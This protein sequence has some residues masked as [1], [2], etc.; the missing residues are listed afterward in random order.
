[1]RLPRDDVNQRMRNIIEYYERNYREDVRLQNDAGVL[2]LAR[3][4]D[5]LRRFLPDPPAMVLDIGGGPGVYASWLASL[6]FEV[7]LLDPVP[8]HLVHAR[9]SLGVG[10]VVFGDARELPFASQSADA[11]LLLGPLYHLI[12]RQDRIAALAEARRVL[13]A[14]GVMV[15]AGISRFASLLDGVTT[16]AIDDPVFQRIVAQDLRDG[17]H[18]SESDRPEYFTTAYFHHP[19]E[20]RGEALEAG[21]IDPEIIAVEGPVW[22]APDFQER[23]RDPERR[24]V[25][26]ELAK[27]V[28]REPSLLGLSL[29]F[30]VICGGAK[31]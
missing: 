25:L 21:F 14:D 3:T 9:D 18:R 7:C 1:M 10:G 13:R 15:A 20:L 24:A 17:Q 23:W 2:E 28:E 5:I 8:R 19:E 16:G 30:L 12:E 11:A 31:R 22:I 26:L 27:A 6:G 4:Q 29:H